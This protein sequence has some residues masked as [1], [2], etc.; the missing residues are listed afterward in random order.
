MAAAMTLPKG[1]A[2]NPTKLPKR[3]KPP[4]KH[5]SGQGI[6][7]VPCD[8]PKGYNLGCPVPRGFKG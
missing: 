4:W 7:R 6:R 8:V 3:Y 2:L 1:G 5:Q